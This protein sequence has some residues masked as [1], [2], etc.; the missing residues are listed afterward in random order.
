M[1]MYLKPHANEEETS[2]VFQLHVTYST[3]DLSVDDIVQSLNGDWFIY[4]KDQNERVC[5]SKLYV[6][7]NA[8]C[9]P[10]LQFPLS[11]QDW[12]WLYVYYPVI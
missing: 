1:H 6:Q 8:F 9:Q 11:L 5:P 2:Y 10:S 7:M 4:V 12:L 3:I